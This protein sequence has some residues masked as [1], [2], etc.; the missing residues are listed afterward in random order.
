M[1][2]PEEQKDNEEEWE[3]ITKLAIVCL[4]VCFFVIVGLTKLFTLYI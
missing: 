2:S 4:L 1:K 3:F